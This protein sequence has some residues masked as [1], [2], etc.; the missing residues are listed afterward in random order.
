MAVFAI[1]LCNF[2][3][4]SYLLV[5]VV[6]VMAAVPRRYNADRVLDISGVPR[7]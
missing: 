4:T 1:V 3:F 7:W 6:H 5:V 2:R